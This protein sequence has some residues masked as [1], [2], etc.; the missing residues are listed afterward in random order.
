M[1]GQDFNPGSTGDLCEIFHRT[2]TTHSLIQIYHYR[3]R[4]R[5]R[6]CGWL[7]ERSIDTEMYNITVMYVH[8]CVLI[9]LCSTSKYRW[10]ESVAL[11]KLEQHRAFWW[12]DNHPFLCSCI[13]Y[14]S[15]WMEWQIPEADKDDGEW[16]TAGQEYF[17]REGNPGWERRDGRRRKIRANGGYQ[18]V[19]TASLEPSWKFSC[20]KCLGSCEWV[21]E[22]YA[23]VLAL[24]PLEWFC[25]NSTS[26]VNF[27]LA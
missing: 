13:S 5:L 27:I 24:M 1:T 4:E 9:N 3:K 15:S 17:H 8:R 2:L 26:W 12:G 22:I 7:S 23:G 14:Q 19:L 25:S 21:I 10:E 18:W 11:C 6:E 16:G 20:E